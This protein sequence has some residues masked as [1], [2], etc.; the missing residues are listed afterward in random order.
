[1]SRLAIAL[2]ITGSSAAF[3]QTNIMNIMVDG[4]NDTTHSPFA[5]SVNDCNHIA[6]ITWSLP[7]GA[8]Q[9]SAAIFVTTAASCPTTPGSADVQVPV[10]A[11]GISGNI[12]VSN[13]ATFQ[14]ADAGTLTCPQPVKQQNKV[15]GTYQVASGISGCTVTPGGFATIYYKGLPPNPP[16][17]D[18]VTPLDT[19]IN[20]NASTTES[21]IVA[22]HV[23]LAEADGGQFQERAV[24]TP[25]VGFAKISGLTDNLTYQVRARAE[26]QIPQFSA[27]SEI[28]EVTP[29]LTQGFWDRYLAAGGAERG[30]CGGIGAMIFVWC[31][32]GV[33]IVSLLRRK[34]SCGRPDKS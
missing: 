10:N 9:N 33:V 25:S 7:N 8:C 27:Y 11:D 28:V 4:Q 29:I 26:D 18:G 20:V 34:R 1:M 31:L 22:I 21:D 2:L 6:R 15:C 12:T 14:T 16:N 17:I 3:A 23:E 13:L 5:L 19:E 32:P 24:F 30:G